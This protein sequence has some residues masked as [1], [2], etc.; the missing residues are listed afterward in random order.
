[1]PEVYGADSRAMPG[2]YGADS[3]T[4]TE[5]YGADSRAMTEVYS[6]NCLL[7]DLYRIMGASIADY[8]VQ[9]TY[10]LICTV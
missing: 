1:M 8:T 3:R 4:M 5:V 2:V 6:A 7:L 10:S 9:I